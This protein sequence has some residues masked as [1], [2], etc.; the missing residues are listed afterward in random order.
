[1]NCTSQGCLTCSLDLTVVSM[2]CRPFCYVNS[3]A[4][5]VAGTCNF[6]CTSPCASCYG[7]N[8]N[9]CLSCLSGY[10]YD[11]QCVSV[12]PQGT[13]IYGSY[14]ERCPFGCQ[15]CSN[16]TICYSC[17]PGYFFSQFS[18]KRLCPSGTFPSLFNLSSISALTSNTTSFASINQTA[19][20]NSSCLPCS[21]DCTR[22]L[23]LLTCFE[24]K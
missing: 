18:C 14:C 12:C 5:A 9:E 17:T 20:L 15:V 7:P 21:Q 19:Y 1:L 10:L 8:S 3:T 24:C 11:G 4:E 6:N 16:S 22:C 13:F 23:D 2:I